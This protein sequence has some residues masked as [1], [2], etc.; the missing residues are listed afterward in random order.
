MGDT[1]QTLIT[2]EETLFRVEELMLKGVV[3]PAEIARNVECSSPQAKDYK[4]AIL[5]RWSL[6]KLRENEK[7][8]KILVYKLNFLE[9]NTWDILQN[10]DNSNAKIGAVGKLMEIFDKQA[11]FRG[12]NIEH[13]LAE[14]NPQAQFIKAIK[15]ISKKN[16]EAEK[17]RIAAEQAGTLPIE[18][19]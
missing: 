4:R 17:E 1:N 3:K 18:T 5:K 9:K 19:L 8:R 11:I 15:S 6:R 16:I 10:A 12:L 2:R 7:Y 14:D 13:C